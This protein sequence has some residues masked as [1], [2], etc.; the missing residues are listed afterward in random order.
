VAT[1]AAITELQRE[2]NLKVRTW[3]LRNE[4]G[5][6]ICLE[7]SKV[8]GQLKSSYINYKLRLPVL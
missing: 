2:P 6:D 5:N 8:V 3:A 1:R 7:N 4:E